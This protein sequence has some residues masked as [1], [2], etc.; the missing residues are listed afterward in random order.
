M[1][2]SDSSSWAGGRSGPV[3]PALAPAGSIPKSFDRSYEGSKALR[4]R[5]RIALT[6]YSV[7]RWSFWDTSV[8]LILLGLVVSFIASIGGVGVFLT[9]VAF[10][11]A[12]AL[13]VLASRL[14]DPSKISRLYANEHATY[15]SNF[16]PD[17]FI[18]Q[19]ATGTYEVGWDSVAS[20]IT[21]E[22]V[23]VLGLKDSSAICVLPEE[24]LTLDA[25]SRIDEL[26]QAK[27]QD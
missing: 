1:V 10:V 25:Q 14:R 9:F 13:I 22:R 20:S 26:A 12:L 3:Y 8:Y 6:A 23:T 18:W 4:R 7:R 27:P 17:S 16:K 21:R 15:A 2:F 11:V 19:T 24:L 5:V